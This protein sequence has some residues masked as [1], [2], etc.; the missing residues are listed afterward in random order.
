METIPSIKSSKELKK[1]LKCA[2]DITDL[3]VEI[4]LSL[5]EEGMKV[6]DI[7]NL[8]KKDRT[9]IQKSLKNLL[10]KELIF[11][12]SKCCVQGKRGRYFIYKSLPREELKKRVLSNIEEWYQELQDSIKSLE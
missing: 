4:I 1:I 2:F 12:E 9:T 10:E 11:R 7:Q 3:E 5:P 8:L 6:K